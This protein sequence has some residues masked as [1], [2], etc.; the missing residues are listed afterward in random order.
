MDVD[1]DGKVTFNEFYEWWT[2]KENNLL[3]LLYVKQ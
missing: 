3:D 1:G 2:S